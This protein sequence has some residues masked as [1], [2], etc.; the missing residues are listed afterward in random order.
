MRGA[1]D[2]LA[3]RTEAVKKMDDVARFRRDQLRAL[4]ISAPTEGIVQEMPLEPGQ[5]VTAGTV[6]A[7]IAKPG[8][9]K[10]ILEVPEALAA[11]VVKGEVVHLT[12]PSSAVEGVVTS[13]APSPTLQKNI[14]LAYVPLAKAAVGSEITLRDPQRGRTATAVVVKTPFYKRAK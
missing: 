1:R 9:L 8:R 13:G 12:L 14:G 11:E 4:A 3:A 5:W 6:L 7:K 10:A 2:E